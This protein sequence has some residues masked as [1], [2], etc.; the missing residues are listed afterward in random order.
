MEESSESQDFFPPGFNR[1]E[2]RK[3]EKGESRKK[4]GGRRGGGRVGF[5]SFLSNPN[6]RRTERRN[7]LPFQTPPPFLL[8]QC[9]FSTSEKLNSHS[10]GIAVF[11]CTEKML[12][13]KRRLSPGIFAAP[14]KEREKPNYL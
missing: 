11:R 13:K 14:G 1:H 4:M 12:S 2:V 6:G 9:P 5:S 7:L 10:R 8:A 3:E